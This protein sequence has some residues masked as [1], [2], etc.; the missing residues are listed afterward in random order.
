M[1]ETVVTSLVADVT[2][3]VQQAG[4]ARMIFMD[5]SGATK[6]YATGKP[7]GGPAPE[8]AWQD[9][10]DVAAVGESCHGVE[11]IGYAADAERLRLDLTAYRTLLPVGVTLSTAIRPMLPDCDGSD[12]LSAKVRIA[13]EVGL[14]WVDFYHYGFMPLDRLD[15]IREA[16]EAS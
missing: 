14:D 9:G 8:I 3:A 2:K 16:L 5:M 4:P 12:N 1:R 11:S 10:V 6:G 13:R 7:T 15:W